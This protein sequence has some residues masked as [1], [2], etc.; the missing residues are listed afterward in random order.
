MPLLLVAL[1]HFGLLFAVP[2][3]ST[4]VPT[5]TFR[6]NLKKSLWKRHIHANFRGGLGDPTLMEFDF[7][8]YLGDTLSYL[9]VYKV[10]YILIRK[11]CVTSPQEIHQNLY[12]CFEVIRILAEEQNKKKK[13][14]G[15]FVKPRCK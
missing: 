1:V 5:I 9:W 6:N 15:G 4:T 8:R 10:S 3:I 2:N 14:I 13:L 11:E 7:F 12:N